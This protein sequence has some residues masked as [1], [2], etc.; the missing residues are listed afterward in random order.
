[1]APFWTLLAPFWAL[2]PPFSTLLAP[3]SSLFAPF[4]TPLA[5]FWSL[6]AAFCSFGSHF[7]YIFNFPT[8]ILNF[9]I[10]KYKI[11]FKIKFS[12]PRLA[13]HLQKNVGT[14]TEGALHF[15]Q[16]PHPPGPER[17]LAVGNLDPLRA[18]R[19]PRRV[20][21]WLLCALPLYF[22]FVNYLLSLPSVGH[23]F[24][25]F[26]NCWPPSFGFLQVGCLLFCSFFFLC[27]LPAGNLVDLY[28]PQWPSVMLLL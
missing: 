20:L 8:P 24:G 26:A 9:F 28:F 21:V 3:F 12:T 2:L 4:W 1:M 15:A 6:L 19:R 16:H 7:S 5:P 18:R 25:V 13:E 23:L 14:F 17:N 27:R 11:S 22:T 10:K